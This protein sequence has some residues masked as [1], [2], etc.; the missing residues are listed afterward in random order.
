MLQYL[1][2]STGPTHHGK[3]WSEM[4]LM[5]VRATTTSMRRP[6]S[7]QNCH[8]CFLV[9]NLTVQSATLTFTSGQASYIRLLLRSNG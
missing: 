8:L 1:A 3:M 7:M 2:L 5:L 6:F 9:A 4:N